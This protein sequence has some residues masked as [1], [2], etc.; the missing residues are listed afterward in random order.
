[1]IVKNQK[2]W[3]SGLGASHIVDPLVKMSPNYNYQNAVEEVHSFANS[4]SALLETGA[5]YLETHSDKVTRDNYN[6]P[7]SDYISNELTPI[8]KGLQ[9][10]IKNGAWDYQGSNE[11]IKARRES[12]KQE[13]LKYID[14]LIKSY[15][16]SPNDAAADELVMMYDLLEKQELNEKGEESNEKGVS[17]FVC[18]F[19]NLVEAIKA[20]E[21]NPT[22]CK[23]GI[24]ERILRDAGTL[25]KSIHEKQAAPL[26]SP[27]DAMLR[28]INEYIGAFIIDGE[29]SPLLYV[30][31]TFHIS[32]YIKNAESPSE[33]SIEMAYNAV[34]EKIRDSLLGYV[35]AL[36]IPWIS[37]VFTKS[38]TQAL[39]D[40]VTKRL[41]EYDFKTRDEEIKNN[42]YNPEADFN[43][44]QND[45]NHTLYI[46]VVTRCLK[47]SPPTGF[48]TWAAFNANEESVQR[49]K[50]E[51]EGSVMQEQNYPIS[52]ITEHANA[53]LKSYKGLFSNIKLVTNKEIT[54][55]L[56]S[57]YSYSDNQFVLREIDLKESSPDACKHAFNEAVDLYFTKN[58]PC[59]LS[60]FNAADISEENY[61]RISKLIAEEKYQYISDDLLQCMLTKSTTLKDRLF[62]NRLTLVIS[63]GVTCPID[64]LKNIPIKQL[65]AV[66]FCDFGKNL[67]MYALYSGNTE[68]FN[69]ILAREDLTTKLLMQRD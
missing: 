19:E 13:L 45:L 39:K 43:Y 64:Y 50:L 34:E 42:E 16:N 41:C 21:G 15:T 55:V 23:Q 58:S 12:D 59:V 2:N 37:G 51:L 31:A 7:A 63:S 57:A 29:P 6:G 35:S 8:L 33:V 5:K 60:A 67:L 36:R 68:M 27:S 9:E 24:K 69:T 25:E 53:I 47:Q 38:M 46:A 20:Y 32:Q 26:E 18:L 62:E 40:T 48:K 44:A 65:E 3:V 66:K 1:M 17:P 30:I 10:K 4:N 28:Y 14:T 22:S 61:H 49:L 56:T 52:V 54:K 11:A